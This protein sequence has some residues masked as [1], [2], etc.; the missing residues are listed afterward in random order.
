MRWLP[1]RVYEN[2]VFAVYTNPIGVEGDTI[3][4]GGSLIFDPFGEILE[5]CRGL[6][7]KLSSRRLIRL[8]W[9]WLRT[10]LHSSSPPRALRED[11]RAESLYG[12][13]GRP[14]VWWKKN[15]K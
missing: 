1:A 4:P 13:D 9:R 11:D 3:K 10:V 14:E 8:S 12:P 7:M 2:G 6:G 5:E 15:R